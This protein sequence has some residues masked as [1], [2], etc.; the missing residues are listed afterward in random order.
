MCHSAQCHS[1]ASLHYEKELINVPLAIAILLKVTI[2]LS[3]IQFVV[4]PLFAILL[5]AFP[6]HLILQSVILQSVILQSIILQSVILQ[7]VI[8]QSVILQSVSCQ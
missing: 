7:R 1:N 4:V 3:C 6:L 2:L 5:N 8:L